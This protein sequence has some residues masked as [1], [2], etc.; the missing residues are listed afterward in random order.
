MPPVDEELPLILINTASKWKKVEL[1]CHSGVKHGCYNEE[2]QSS[3]EFVHCWWKID[4]I[5]MEQALVLIDQ[6]NALF[7]VEFEISKQY[8]IW[9]MCN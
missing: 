6:I 3:I 8:N 9:M 2:Q 7:I 4:E 1:L 5:K